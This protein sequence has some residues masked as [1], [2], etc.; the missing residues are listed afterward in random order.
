MSA[1]AQIIEMSERR[2]RSMLA[3]LLELRQSMTDELLLL[4]DN[5]KRIDL[6]ISALELG[7]DEA[8]ND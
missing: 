5:I 6:E 1:C 2:E 7:L 8:C 4:I 3:Q